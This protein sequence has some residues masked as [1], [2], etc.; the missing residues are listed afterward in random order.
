MAIRPDLKRA[1]PKTKN[2]AKDYNDNFDKM[3]DYVDA[4]LTECEDYVDAYMPSQTGQ[5][6]K[7][8]S[9][10]GTE[11]SWIGL[12]ANF[13]FSK[14]IDGLVITKENSNTIAVDKGSCYDQTG[15]ILLSLNSKTT[16]Q[17]ETQSA[18]T[19]YYV[20]IIGTGSAIDIFIGL[21]SQNPNLPSGYIYYRLIGQYSTDENNEITSV[22]S[23]G[24]NTSSAEAQALSLSFPDYTAQVTLSNTAQDSTITENGWLE[25]NSGVS[26]GSVSLTLN[27]TTRVINYN[28]STAQR[29]DLFLPVSKND[30]FKLSSSSLTTV[31]FYPMR[32]N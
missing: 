27:G 26:P 22:Y 25:I 30:V 20:F 13:P 11:A 5:G 16:K 23:F 21:S 31:Y 4:T 19:T 14:Y 9:T 24:I 12:G 2:T 17:N 28:S 1:V 15:N 32:S 18:N 3:M 29:L 8:L 10:N 6:G 7:V